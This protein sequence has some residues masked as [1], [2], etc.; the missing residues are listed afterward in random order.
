MIKKEREAFLAAHPY[1]GISPAGIGASRKT[2]GELWYERFFGSFA[3]PVLRP[4]LIPVCLLLLMTMMAVPF[5]GRFMR[6]TSLTGVD[7]RYKGPVAPASQSAISG[8]SY[9][10]KRDGA[11]RES[12]PGDV[13]KAGDK[14]QVFYASSRDQFLT[15]VSLDAAGTVSFYQPDARASVCSIRS[16]VGTRIAYPQSIG[17][18][19]APG[20]ELV[21]ALF[22]DSVFTMEQ[23]RQWVAGVYAK[24]KTA[25]ELEATVR[26]NPLGKS[27]VMTL[28]LEKR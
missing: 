18:D 28:V 20:A 14:V 27:T 17:L 4:V 19:D 7:L 13:F 22:S 15:L 9:I 2:G 5:M 3:L 26:G 1:A 21:V 16:G 11:I 8:L 25:A 23:V 12:A 10:Y 6:E 24:G